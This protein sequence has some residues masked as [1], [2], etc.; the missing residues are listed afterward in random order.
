MTI[1]VHLLFTHSA[2]KG[3]SGFTMRILNIDIVHP[4][5]HRNLICNVVFDQI[6][7]CYIN[8]MKHSVSEVIEFELW[9]LKSARFRPKLN[10]HKGNYIMPG[11]QN[12]PI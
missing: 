9:G 11:S 12:V 2:V 4:L 6:F 1:P 10:I 8:V 7:V 5:I 3:L